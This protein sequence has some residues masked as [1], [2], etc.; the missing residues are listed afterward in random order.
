MKMTSR[1]LRLG[2]AFAACA[3][4]SVSAAVSAQN[5]YLP[6]WEHIPDGEPYVFEDPDRPG[7]QRVYVFGS[8]DTSGNVYWGSDQVVWSAPVENLNDWRYDGVIF[9]ST[10]D[11]DGR[12]LNSD[13]SG[14]ILYAPDIVEVK[15]KEGR[16]TYYF[17]PNT[18]A[19]ER[20]GM[21]AKSDRPD[22]PFEVCNWS[23]TDPTVTTGILRFDPAVFVDDDGKLYGYW[24]FGTS[25]G[26][27][28]DPATMCTVK[29][30]TQAVEGL[31]SGFQEDGDFR[32]YEASSIRKVKDKYI[33]IY[34]RVTKDGEFGLHASNNTLAYAYRDNPL[35]PFTYGGT[36]IDGR[37]RGKDENGHAIPTGYPN[38]NTHGSICEIDGK[39]WVFYHRHTGTNE[40]ARQPM[41]APVD[42][43]VEEGKGGKVY[44]S[45]GEYTSEGFSTG[46]LDPRAKTPAGIACHFVGPEIATETFPNFNFSGP[47]IKS[48]YFDP[49]S[50]EGPFNQ[51]IPFNP[52]V[53]NTSGSTV[54]Y[55]YFD[56]SKLDT[57]RP[58][59]FVCHIVPEGTDGKVTILLGSP[60]KSQG[61][62]EI[63][64]FDVKTDMPRELTEIRTGVKGLTGATGKQALYFLF[65]SPM[66]G[67]SICEFHDFRFI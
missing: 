62:K 51:K 5:P 35:G 67:K 6:L 40:Y 50:Y 49:E 30:G 7:H 39:W 21:V 44:I 45:E 20:A 53:N 22:G 19:A 34:S 61:A 3:M 14:D 63:G 15:D 57:R 59:E 26:A 66:A 43:K 58:V 64:S 10:T 37:S 16:K 32:F 23:E 8:H 28:L 47:Y 25:W 33:L 60:Y 55:K 56:F 27:E 52:I 2:K 9:R 48:T 1:V 29:P 38:G 17:Y 65:E 42:V 11:R 36:I 18:Q 12:P 24:G 4:L 54:G 31:I 13:G 46:G 41:V